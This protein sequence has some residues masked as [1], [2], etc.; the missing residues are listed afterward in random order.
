MPISLRECMSPRTRMPPAKNC[1][2]ASFVPAQDRHRSGVGRRSLRSGGELSSPPPIATVKSVA[3]SVKLSPSVADVR[4]TIEPARSSFSRCSRLPT[5]SIASRNT[6]M[7]VDLSS[8]R[9]AR[10]RL[11]APAGRLPGT[12]SRSSRHHTAHQARRSFGAPNHHV[13]SQSSE[14]STGSR[15]S[16]PIGRRDSQMAAEIVLIALPEQGRRVSHLGAE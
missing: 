14:A 2:R 16:R 15:R 3:R 8:A 12:F 7:P 5:A 13:T 4:K 10:R 1:T 6:S 11:P 9:S